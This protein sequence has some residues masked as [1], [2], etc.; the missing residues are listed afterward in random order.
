MF[1][2]T[3]GETT[4]AIGTLPTKKQFHV[5]RRLTPFIGSVLPHLAVLQNKNLSVMEKAAAILPA[6][7]DI[8]AKLSDEECDYVIDACLSV[9]KMKQATGWANLTNPSG[10]FQ[11]PLTVPVMLQLTGEV[12]RVNLADFF[13]TGSPEESADSPSPSTSPA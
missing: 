4:Y 9:V 6:I 11:F 13:P 7:A 5:E 2:T 12:V 1:E 10:G 8:L 3:I